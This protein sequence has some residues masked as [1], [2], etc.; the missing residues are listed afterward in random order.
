MEAEIR[1]PLLSNVYPMVA[2]NM[3][4]NRCRLDGAPCIHWLILDTGF[5]SPLL[6]SYGPASWILDVDGFHS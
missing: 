5:Q 3:T 1:Q 2:L 4:F 6:Q